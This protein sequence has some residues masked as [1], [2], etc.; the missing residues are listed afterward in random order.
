MVCEVWIVVLKCRD[1]GFGFVIEMMR[2]CWSM[3]WKSHKL[4]AVVME[5]AGG[6]T[7]VRELGELP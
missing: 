3:Q 2:G 4:D 1:C 7:V 5:L 6:F